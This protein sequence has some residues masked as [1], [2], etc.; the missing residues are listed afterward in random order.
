[1]TEE[2]KEKIKENKNLVYHENFDN[3]YKYSKD[4]CP[5]C[6]KYKCIYCNKASTLFNANCCS[7][8]LQNACGNETS[9]CC[10][11]Y[12]IFIFALFVPIIRVFYMAS[13]VNFEYFRG[14]TMEKKLLQKKK[15]IIM[16]DQNHETSE[17]V[18]GTYQ[19]KFKRKYMI[20]ISLLNIFGSICWSL[21]F[22]IFIEII[23]NISMFLGFCTKIRLFKYLT[24]KY[25]FLAFVPGLRRNISGN[26]KYV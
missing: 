1:M 24:S 14:L 4:R 22:I 2:Q 11:Y 15:N 18:F 9:S 21:P 6:L 16:M 26:I 7:R 13:M 3:I 17:N 20:I 23:L 25:Y 19:S 8:Q 5:I 10:N 12:G